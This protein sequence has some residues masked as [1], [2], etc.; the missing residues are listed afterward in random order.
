MGLSQ[1]VQA[2]QANFYL[3]LVKKVGL[4]LRELLASVDRLIPLFPSNTHRQVE[5]AHKVLSK[6]MSDLVNSMKLA[7]KYN[8]TTVEADYRKGM[9]SSA[10]IL[11]MDAKNLLD[12]IDTIRQNYPKVDQLIVRGRSAAPAGSPRTRSSNSTSSGS[13]SG[14]SSAASSLEKHRES[15]SPLSSTRGSPAM[16]PLH[17]QNLGSVS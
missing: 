9:L 12:V 2:H 14:S 3:D 8:N 15:M 1:G 16:S 4:E 7:Q 13:V 11:A 17:R 6:D 10:H 5:M